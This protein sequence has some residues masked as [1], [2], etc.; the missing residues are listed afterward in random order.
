MLV[1]AAAASAEPPSI[2]SKRSEARRILA[3]VQALD[4]RLEQSV[5]AYNLARIKLAAAERSLSA[6]GRRLKI[7]R[8]N[9]ARAHRRHAALLVYLYTADEGRSGVEVL[10]GARSLRDVLDRLDAARRVAEEDAVVLEQ[11]KVFEAQA[12]RDQKRLRRTRAAQARLT[13]ELASRRSGI[14]DQLTER[15]RLLSS[16]KEEIARLEAR[17]RERQERL[18]REAQARL[19]AERAAREQ[20]AQGAQAGEPPEPELGLAAVTPDGIGVAPDTRH[21]HVVGI[22]MRYLGI[23]YK[24]GGASPQEGFDCS[25]FVLYVYAQVGISLP[26]NAAMQYGYG[27]PVAKEDL[28][29]GDIVFFNNLGHNG[30]Y[31]GGGQFIQAPRTGDVVKISSLSEPWYASMYYGARRLP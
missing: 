30:I 21:A 2:T 16:V 9:L 4:V 5:E 20:A 28:Q 29:P 25:G 23:P 12:V 26:H 14:E 17:E 18:L 15:S 22:A 13:A 11:V 10:L 24:W 6:N 31:I 27:V 7:A 3:E 19:A 8:R 1:A